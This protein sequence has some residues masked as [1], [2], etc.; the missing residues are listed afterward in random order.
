MGSREASTCSLSLKEAE[1]ELDGVGPT[2]F[3]LR[4]L[5]QQKTVVTL[6]SHFMSSGAV[7]VL[8]AYSKG[9]QGKPWSY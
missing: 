1:P 2:K 6:K 5:S 7:F 4:H 3:Q 9:Y 8:K